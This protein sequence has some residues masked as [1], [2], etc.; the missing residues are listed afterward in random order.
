MSI[1]FTNGLFEYEYHLY[2][3]TKGIAFFKF[4]CTYINLIIGLV[5]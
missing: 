5:K 4:E 3:W 2:N 1:N